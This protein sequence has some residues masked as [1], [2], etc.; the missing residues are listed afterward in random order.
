MPTNPYINLYSA[1]NEQTLIENLIIESIKFYGFDT[2]YL[3]RQL[4][5]F[6]EV[7]R[8]SPSSTFNTSYTFEVYLKSNMKFGG[9]GKFMSE[10]L[11]LEI[12][13]QSV[14]TVSQSVFK[15]ITGMVRPREGD[16]VYLPLDKKT[17]EIK[18]V[19]HQSVF[20][21]LGKL[22]VWDLECELLE[23]NGERFN[24]GIPDIDS[25]PTYYN[26]DDIEDNEQEDWTDQSDE[27]QS[28]SNTIVTWTE[29]D[30]LSQ[31]G[32]T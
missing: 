20:Y 3:V 27:I 23:Y 24:T 12:R 6:D 17:Y 11:G 10:Q 32:T 2:H 21:Q 30:P 9:D 18:F 28:V 31:G 29:D 5:D 25:I 7:F 13:D 4:D 15:S 14:F 26:F 1:N 16:L 22:M 19:Q 8:E